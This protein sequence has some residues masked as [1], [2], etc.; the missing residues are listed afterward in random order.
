MWF[1]AFPLRCKNLIKKLTAGMRHF[2]NYGIMYK[3]NYEHM[4]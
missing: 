1:C 3:G 2:Q 4:R